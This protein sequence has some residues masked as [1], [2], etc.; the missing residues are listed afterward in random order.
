MK[1]WLLIKDSN[2]I[3]NGNRTRVFADSYAAYEA[4]LEDQDVPDAPADAPAVQTVATVVAGRGARPKPLAQPERHTTRANMEQFFARRQAASSAAAAASSSPYVEGSAAEP[5]A[6]SSGPESLTAGVALAAVCQRL[7][8]LLMPRTIEVDVPDVHAKTTVF[9]W[10]HPPDKKLREQYPLDE[11]VRFDRFDFSEFLVY[12]KNNTYQQDEKSRNYTVRCIGRFFSLLELPEME[13]HPVG[14]LC[15]IYRNDVLGQ[16][17]DAPML[18][19][20]YGFARGIISALDHYVKHLIIVCGRNRWPEAK[21]A[22]PD[23]FEGGCFLKGDSHHQNH[24]TTQIH[25]T[26]SC[27]LKSALV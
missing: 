7:D 18:D 6:A 23:A 16:L 8:L 13:V 3:H 5:Q 1:T 27:I 15:G 20:R 9:E 2:A 21:A 24:S 4:W 14:V 12:L 11:S 22:S 19:P 17:R 26:C 25:K 10:Q